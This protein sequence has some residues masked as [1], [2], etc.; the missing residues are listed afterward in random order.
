MSTHNDDLSDHS[1]PRAV[2]EE[3]IK[4]LIHDPDELPSYDEECVAEDV[5]HKNQ[6]KTVAI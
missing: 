6:A 3:I 1:L 2:D 4:T 5:T